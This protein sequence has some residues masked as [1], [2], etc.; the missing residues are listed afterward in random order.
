MT[1]PTQQQLTYLISRCNN[2]GIDVSLSSTITRGFDEYSVYDMIQFAKDVGA[3]ALRIRK[4]YAQGLSPSSI[5]KFFAGIKPMHESQCPVCRVKTQLIGGMRVSWHTGVMEPSDTIKDD[6]Y[7]IILQPNGKLT[8]D[9]AGNKPFSFAQVDSPGRHSH[10]KID[11][12]GPW[13]GQGLQ[14]KGV[15][16]CGSIGC[17]NYGC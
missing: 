4:D 5:E 8:L 2:V 1:V 7:E 3:S 15:G 9:Y 17:G 11:P 13:C 14:R 16:S 10:T 12:E 6:V